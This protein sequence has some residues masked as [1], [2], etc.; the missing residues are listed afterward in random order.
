[1]GR[2][3]QAEAPQARKEGQNSTANTGKAFTFPF[4][5]SN[6]AMALAA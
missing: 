3:L 5:R 2:R 4:A 6:A 1:M